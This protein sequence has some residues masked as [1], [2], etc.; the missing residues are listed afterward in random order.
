[1]NPPEEHYDRGNPMSSSILEKIKNTVPNQF[2]KNIADLKQSNLPVYFYG[3]GIAGEN[4]KKVLED[5]CIGID[6]FVVDDN[7][8]KQGLNIEGKPV[9][10]LSGVLASNVSVNF[11]VADCNYC[12]KIGNTSKN[13]F[14]IFDGKHIVSPFPDY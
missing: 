2:D 3:A 13:N 10:P 6:S 11:V 8:F 14:F 7:C 5:N 1:L 12:E 9:Y 4:I